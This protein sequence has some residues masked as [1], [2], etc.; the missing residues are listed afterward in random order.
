[1]RDGYPTPTRSLFDMKKF[2][3]ILS[4]YAC[5]FPQLDNSAFAIYFS[6]KH[7]NTLHIHYSV[8]TSNTQRINC[9]F[10]TA[11]SK[12][13]CG[14]RASLERSVLSAFLSPDILIIP[15]S[16]QILL[17]GM[18]AKTFR[19]LH[20]WGDIQIC[21]NLFGFSFHISY[22][23]QFHYTVK[24]RSSFHDINPCWQSTLLQALSVFNV[25]FPPLIVSYSS[26]AFS[27]RFL[28]GVQTRRFSFDE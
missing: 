27:K 11:F 18:A 20:I 23:K 15:F 16:A 25:T 13:G 1:M 21:Y 26:I 14:C 22:A 2:A 24:R 10:C 19:I 6:V 12:T 9:D 7:K 4:V 28:S 3:K 8:P 5:V 17:F